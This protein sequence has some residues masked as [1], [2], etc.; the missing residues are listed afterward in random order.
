MLPYFTHFLPW[1]ELGTWNIGYHLARVATFFSNDVGDD[2]S[3]M[4]AQFSEADARWFQT[5]CSQI[6]IAQIRPQ[7]RKNC[8]IISECT[9]LFSKLLKIIYHMFF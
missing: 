7:P 9:M 2:D 4:S 8:N 6:K 1:R 5:T 3:S